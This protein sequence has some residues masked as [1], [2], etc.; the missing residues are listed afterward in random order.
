MLKI[1]FLSL[2][3]LWCGMV[4]SISFL[5]APL[6]FRAPGIT[7]ALG[8]GIGRLV[9]GMLNKIECVF[10]LAWLVIFVA[11]GYQGTFLS[12]MTPVGIVLLLQTRWLLPKLDARVKMVMEGKTPPRDA[13][14]IYY[15]AGEVIKCTMLLVIGFKQLSG[16]TI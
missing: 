5:E 14:H 10:F 6:K 11:G 15:V 2:P 8:S 16:L 12:L 3:L 1:L 4:M 7:P 9:F 13:M